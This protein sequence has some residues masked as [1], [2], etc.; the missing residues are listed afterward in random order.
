MKRQRDLFLEGEGDA[1]LDRN[2]S[3][4]SKG[5]S[6]W[7]QL[8]VSAVEG[9]IA[10]GSLPPTDH[11]KLL[12]IGCA[13]GTLGSLLQDRTGSACSGLEPSKR[14][15]SE[16]REK[17]VEAR[18]GTADSIPFDD[19]EFDV[20]IY[21][22]C[23]YLCDPEDY[24]RIISECQRVA[25]PSAWV[26]ILDFLVPSP[27]RRQYEHAEGVISYKRDWP[28]LFEADTAFTELFRYTGD[29]ADASFT[30]CNDDW[31]SLSGM[32]RTE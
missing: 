4:L 31:V 25:K 21:A 12:E 13:D 9:L 17:G 28:A 18:R 27:T 7:H 19:A 26:L 11:T 10:S 20:I 24:N 32:F 23:L 16:A 8:V 3:T 2:R 14:G 29:H 5:L 6:V 22:F 30:T 1:W 15:V